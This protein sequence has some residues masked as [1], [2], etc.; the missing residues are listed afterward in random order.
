MKEGLAQVNGTSLYYEIKG[1][2]FPLVF[3]SGGGVLDRRGWDDQFESFAEYYRVIRY[4]VRGIGKSARPQTVF[5][6]SQDLYALLKFLGIK[7]AHLVGLSVGGAIGIDFTL[8]HREMVDHLIL[9]ASGVSDDAKA[10]ANLQGL[11]TLA[12][13]TK[14]EGIERVIQLPL[15]LRL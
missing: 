7:R 10:G 2:G 13:L 15:I 14:T 5:S 9:A 1:K 4:D 8:E 3:V 12:T 6:H 11:T